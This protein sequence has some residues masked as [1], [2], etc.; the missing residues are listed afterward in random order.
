MYVY[1]ELC[2][3]AETHIT[4]QNNYTPEGESGD[5]HKKS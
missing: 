3:A 1:I 4:L 2:Y 5:T